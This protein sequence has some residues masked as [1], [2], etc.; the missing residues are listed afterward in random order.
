[1]KSLALRGNYFVREKGRI[2]YTKTHLDFMRQRVHSVV[3]IFLG[4]W[5]LDV[6][7]GIPYLPKDDNRTGHRSLIESFLITKVTAIEGI[8]R[9]AQFASAYDPHT[10][11]LSIDFVAETD[12]GEM[13]EM[14]DVWKAP[15]PGGNG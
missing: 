10:R 11:K 12:G 13:L 6:N 15:T 3:S 4:E 9:M 2:T 8:K 14:K 1:M 7:L 5:F